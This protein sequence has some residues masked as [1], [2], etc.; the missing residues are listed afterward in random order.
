MP[1]LSEA[2]VKKLEAAWSPMRETVSRLGLERLD[3][4][5][6]TGWSV[7]EMLAHV[8]FWDEAVL[9]VVLGM[10][11]HEPLPEGWTFGSGYL[12]AAGEAWAPTEVHN[13]REAAWARTRSGADVLARLDCAHEQLVA[14]LATITDQEVLEHGDYFHRLPLHYAEH[15]PELTEI[16]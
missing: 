11:R 14:L 4:T 1:Q 12:P 6:S 8:A 7:K 2:V 16:V 15:H 3:T 10:F 5:T 9:G 13:A